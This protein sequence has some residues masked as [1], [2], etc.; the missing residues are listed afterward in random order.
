MNDFVF[1]RTAKVPGTRRDFRHAFLSISQ[2][3]NNFG[4]ASTGG[5]EHEGRTS[6][7][8]VFRRDALGPGGIPQG[9]LLAH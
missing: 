4:N 2:V 6:S 9:T 1:E 3:Q 7:S 8:I 5:E